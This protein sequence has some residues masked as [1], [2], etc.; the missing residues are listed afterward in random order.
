[1]LAELA[2]EVFSIERVP[3]LS[4]RA[5]TVL[6]GLG[7]HN[8]ELTIGD[9]SLGLPKVAPFDAVMVTAAAPQAPKSLLAQMVDGGRLV[10]PIGP[11]GRNQLLTLYARAGDAWSQ[12][13]QIDCRFVPLIGAE[14]FGEP[15][16]NE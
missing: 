15:T 7:Y 6:A 14:G 11:A 10:V 12:V 13:D 4:A 1:V 8:V 16:E 3:D 9:G 5:R 2:G